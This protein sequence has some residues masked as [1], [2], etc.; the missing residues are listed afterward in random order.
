MTN[1]VCEISFSAVHVGVHQPV[2][3]SCSAR[4]DGWGR[5]VAA[6]ALSES[7]CW[8]LV[9]L[10]INGHQVMDEPM[11]E[12]ESF[13]HCV[14]ITNRGGPPAAREGV[15]RHACLLFV[16]DEGT[17]KEIPITHHVKEGCEKADPSQFE[18]LKVLGQGSFGKVSG[19]LWCS[20][21]YT[22]GRLFLNLS[23]PRRYFLSGRFWVQMLVS[24][25]QWKF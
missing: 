7:F 20:R 9:C 25:M 8:N 11:E 16:Q 12:G 4:K 1:F 3:P 13:S 14:S 17:Y 21:L 5:I 2:S 24:Y 10:Q 15:W 6:F 19:R 22:C 23:C 18:L